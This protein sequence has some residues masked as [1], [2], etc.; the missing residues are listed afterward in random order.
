MVDS[1]ITLERKVNTNVTSGLTNPAVRDALRLIQ[2]NFTAKNRQDNKNKATTSL[3]E[4]GFLIREPQ[5]PRIISP[6]KILQASWKLANKLKPLDFTF[7]AAGRMSNGDMSPAAAMIP[8][9]SWER[10]VGD[11]VSTVLKKGQ[12]DASF[13]DKGGVFSN[14]ILYGDGFR[15]L[16]PWLEKSLP[17]RFTSIV[18]SNI[19]VNVHATAFRRG[20][21]PVTKCAVVFSGIWGEFCSIFPD[22]ADKAGIGQIP[23]DMGQMKETNET[24]TQRM[25]GSSRLIEWCYY[26]DIENRNFTLFA[27]QQCTI[28]KEYNGK[29]YPYIL[30]DEDSNEE[31]YIPVSQYMMWPAAEGFYN[32][33]LGDLLYEYCVFYSR[34]FNQMAGYINENTFPI[35]IVNVP[36]GESSKFFAALEGAY[37][38]RSL[39]RRGFVP[40]ETS[41]T[42]PKSIGTRPFSGG[43]GLVN[44]ATMMF[45]RID[46]EIKR[47]GL[48][49]DESQGQNTTATQVLA[50]SEN[51]DQFAQQIMEYNASETE[52]ELEATLNAIKMNVKTSNKTTL[53]ITT[54]LK[55]NNGEEIQVKRITLG[56]VADE[57][58]KNKY[59][60]KVNSRTGAIPSNVMKR[61]KL[62]N[63]IALLPPGSPQQMQ[64]AKQIAALDDVSLSFDQP[65]QQPAEPMPPTPPSE[66]PMPGGEP[67]PSLTPAPAGPT[68][69]NQPIV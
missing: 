4:S 31:A 42:D 68:N 17:I 20:S 11:G 26:F 24:Y 41:P 50:D 58:R 22:Y 40:L 21:K 66:M 61:A 36:Q 34:M 8:T 52:F 51:A 3:V 39:G 64:V 23:R 9:E 35:E 13:R 14:M 18:N 62:M 49:L 12:Y 69:P 65:E 63:T 33:G 56:A 59:F 10:L 44:E 57:L 45:D 29:D 6:K 53:N 7:H 19:Y 25:Q 37:E 32:H 60:F 55:L 16:G 43:G 47:L 46:L 27:G 30:K 15:L 28:L 5:G 1:R 54:P 2:E 48:H 67:N 38:Q